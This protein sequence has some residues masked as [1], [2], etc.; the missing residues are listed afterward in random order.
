MIASDM[1]HK[2]VPVMN[3]TVQGGRS[4]DL[5]SNWP[6]AESASP[7]PKFSSS[8]NWMRIRPQSR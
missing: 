8:Y 7:I 1:T 6:K 2:R 4:P 3:A 5:E